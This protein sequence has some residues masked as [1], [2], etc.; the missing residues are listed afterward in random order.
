[1]LN[2]IG[3]LDSASDP[4]TVHRDS[5]TALVQLFTNTLACILLLQLCYGPHSDRKPNTDQQI[6]K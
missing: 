6:V 3:A 2:V 1:M 5:N 4:I